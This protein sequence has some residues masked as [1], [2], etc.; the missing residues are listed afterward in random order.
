MEPS[1]PSRPSIRGRV[2]RAHLPSGTPPITTP[3][4][5]VT[6]EEEAMTMVAVSDAGLARRVA[7]DR[8]RSVT[9]ASDAATM[10]RM[11]TLDSRARAALK[12]SAFAYVDSQGRRR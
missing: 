11:P 9:V 1:L 2:R 4:D 10:V 3:R 12:D 5:R 7:R 6:W 8:S